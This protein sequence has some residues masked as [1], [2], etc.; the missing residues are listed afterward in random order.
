MEFKAI[1]IIV[2]VTYLCIELIKITF[3]QVKNNGKIIPLLASVIGGLFGVIIYLVSPSYLQVNN[4][5]V[6]LE[7]GIISGLA[8]TGTNQII[9]KVFS[10]YDGEYS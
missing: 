3:Q 10:K 7:L 4:I 6:A 1:P 2:I 8:S 5:W 9:K